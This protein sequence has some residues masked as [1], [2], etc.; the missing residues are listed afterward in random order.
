MGHR[1]E[2]PASSGR[3]TS[4]RFEKREENYQKKKKGSAIRNRRKLVTRSF[5]PR[6]II[7]EEG[8]DPK[9]VGK[10]EE[11]GDKRRIFQGKE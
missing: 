3:A 5:K 2:I 1:R 7:E 4:S 11:R 9:R 8:E 10:R 6:D